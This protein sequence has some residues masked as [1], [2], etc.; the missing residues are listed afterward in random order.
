MMCYENKTYQMK[1]IC[2]ESSENWILSDAK[3]VL[4]QYFLIEFRMKT[5]SKYSEQSSQIEKVHV[6]IR[7]NTSDVQIQKI[8]CF[9]G[10]E[11]HEKE[12]HQNQPEGP[13]KWSNE[14][15]CFAPMIS[16]ADSARS[17]SED[18]TDQKLVLFQYVWIE[19]SIKFYLKM[20]R[21][22]FW[23]RKSSNFNL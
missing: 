17:E 12:L 19:S 20:M 2:S 6:W 4:S 18:L 8:S 23:N 1:K 5:C 3:L 10:H 14:G 15:E 13:P 16:G 9:S 7:R 11:S 22:V 21:T